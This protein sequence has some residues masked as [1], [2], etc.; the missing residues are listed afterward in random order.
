MLDQ[1]FDMLV[2]LT[3]KKRISLCII[4]IYRS[5][6]DM[7]PTLSITGRLH[8]NRG[9]R[10]AG[11]M[12][13]F[14]VHLRRF[15]YIIPYCWKYR[16]AVRDQGE[17]M[18]QRVVHFAVLFLMVFQAGISLLFP[19]YLDQGWIQDTWF[20]NDLVTFF[21][22]CPLF[23]VSLLQRT[24]FFK[25]VRNGCLGYVLYNY[26]F[27]ALGTEINTLFLVYVLLISLAVISLIQVFSTEA[28]S[29]VAWNYFDADK[30]YILPGVIFILIGIGLGSVWAGSWIA[31][32]FFK[33]KLPVE[34]AAFRLVAVLDLVIIV[35]MMLISGTALLRKKMIGFIIGPIIGI[36]GSL[37]LLILAVNSILIS[38]NQNKVSGE[39]PVWGT[40]FA[41][42]LA[43]TVSLLVSGR[44]S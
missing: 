39:L 20:G 21:I 31:Y 1:Y 7:G 38:I 10:N 22:V 14:L 5:V 17:V 9:G 19:V 41:V 36:Q 29:R 42:T 2:T 12:E 3:L 18:N 33:G 40:L 34:M 28:E 13:G 11:V 4:S 25:L 26:A 32:S 30:N 37:Y 6:I 35:N 16:A 8:R 43:G 44:K 24:S 27:Y 23:L 15:R